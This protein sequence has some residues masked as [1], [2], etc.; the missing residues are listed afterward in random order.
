MRMW[1]RCRE[2]SE[3]DA[4]DEMIRGLESWMAG[5]GSMMVTFVFRFQDAE[6]G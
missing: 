6:Y 2:A 4:H 5:L 3:M 1:S